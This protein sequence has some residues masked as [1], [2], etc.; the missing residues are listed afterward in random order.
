MWNRGQ[1]MITR[2]WCFS[3]ILTLFCLH[4]V[5]EPAFG[6]T[7]NIMPLGNSITRGYSGS[8][9]ET[10]YRRS[11]YLLLTGAG[12]TVDFVG[13]LDDGIPI[14]F[15]RD[16]E[17][18]SGWCDDEVADNIYNWLTANPVAIVL[19]HIG[20]NMVDESAADV[21]EILNEIDRYESDNGVIIWVIRRD[22]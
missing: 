5:L 3:S 22:H 2:G 18:H 17:G 10:G 8:S 15:D 16:H 1:K 21:E 13:S 4:M 9:D 19:L 14:D 20:T 6:E 11:L 12:Y 7:I